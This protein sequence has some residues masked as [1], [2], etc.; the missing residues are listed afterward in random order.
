MLTKTFLAALVSGL[1]TTSGVAQAETT[2]RYSSFVPATHFMNEGAFLPWAD[3]VAEATDGRVRI[4]MTP[5][6]VGSAA[7]QYDVLSDGL[8]DVAIFVPGYTPGR[9][10]LAGLGELPMLT[11]NPEIGAVAFQ[12]LYDTHLAQTGLFRDVHVLAA[13]T[14]SAGHFFTRNVN[15]KGIEDLKGLKIRAAVPSTV[16]L[17]TELGAVPVQKPVTELYELL[18][19]GAMDGS[20]SGLDQVVSFKLAEVTDHATI[21]PGGL[22]NTVLV[23]AM[24]QMAWDRLAPEDQQAITKLS[25]E[26]LARRV[27]ATFHKPI[28]TGIATMREQGKTVE[29]AD[30]AF[31]AEIA[32]RAAPVEGA[33]MDMAAKKGLADPAA[34]MA[35]YRQQIAELAKQ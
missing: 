34:V 7:S 31:V 8:A 25:G 9:F 35:W 28:E 13:F 17:L 10:D 11:E 1:I 12:R 30:D 6:V 2:L 18:A 26:A 4:E 14:V 29:R 22:F 32:E 20:V 23:F 33:A 19:S 16:P 3:D 24:S 21:I 5:K 15:L 27:G